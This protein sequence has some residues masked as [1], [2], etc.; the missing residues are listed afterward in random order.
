M[1]ENFSVEDFVLEKTDFQICSTE[2][3]PATCEFNKYCNSIFSRTKHVFILHRFQFILE[4]VC[5]GR[6]TW[7]NLVRFRHVRG[8]FSHS[9]FLRK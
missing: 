1:E 5:M 8:K 6:T 2:N 7:N 3:S 4:Y 9:I